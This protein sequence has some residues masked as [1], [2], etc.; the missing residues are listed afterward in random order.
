LFI[1]QYKII[2]TRFNAIII[3]Y[4]YFETYD[5]ILEN[6]DKILFSIRINVLDENDEIPTFVRDKI[7][8]GVSTEDKFNQVVERLQ[9]CIFSLIISYDDF[10]VLFYFGK[11]EISRHIF[12][13]G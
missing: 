2:L 8:A 1:G 3:F 9:V 10:Q 5:K 4:E 11:L 13:I 12:S 6:D 7:F